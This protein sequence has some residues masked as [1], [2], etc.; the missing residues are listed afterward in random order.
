M[1]SENPYAV[2]QGYERASEPVLVASPLPNRGVYFWRIGQLKADLRQRPLSDREALPY[3]VLFMT[4][5]TA[6]AGIPM[7]N[8]NVWDALG[9]V[10]SVAMAVIGTLYIYVRNGGSSGQHFVQRFFAIGWVVAVRWAVALIAAM[11]C[12][13]VVYQWL[14]GWSDDTTPADFVFLA[15]A[16]AVLYW[17]IG[18][19]VGDVAAEHSRSV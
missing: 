14:G 17:R 1:S 2:P 6:G 5:T 3:L 10:W 18:H 4:L 9:T 15:A 11:I 7:D 8:Y 16:E 12:L 19:H 13:A